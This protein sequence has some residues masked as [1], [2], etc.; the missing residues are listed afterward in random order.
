MFNVFWGNL[1]VKD[2]YD[3][4]VHVS[5]MM[6]KWNLVF[7][8]KVTYIFLPRSVS[9]VR[10]LGSTTWACDAALCGSSHSCR[11]S[12]TAC[13]A[14]SGRRSTFPT[15]TASGTSSSS[16]HRRSAAFCLRISTPKKKSRR[17]IRGWGSGRVTNT[18]FVEF[19]TSRSIRQRWANWNRRYTEDT[20]MWLWLH[21]LP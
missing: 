11:G 16:S 15:C 6:L 3:G 5:L 12:P 19:P 20:S 17:I 9:D 14:T 10:H 7:S 21:V 4:I 18:T 2:I 13:S 8:S 1:V